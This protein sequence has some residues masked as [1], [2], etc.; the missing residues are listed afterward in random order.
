MVRIRAVM[1]VLLLCVLV[2]GLGALSM[3]AQVWW[4]LPEPQGRLVRGPNELVGVFSGRS[5]GWVVPTDDPKGVVLVDAG[6]QRAASRILA[7]LRK[8]EREVRAILLTHAHSYTTLG[9]EA[10][11]DV[12]VY[13]A[14]EE[15]PL[16]AGE[17]TPIGWL[18]RIYAPSAAPPSDL[19]LVQDGEVVTIDGA[20][21]VAIAT[22][23]HTAGSTTWWW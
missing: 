17:V 8:G 4:S 22:P 23:G 9:L 14:A 2:L 12:P 11:V 13:L 6:G 16:L 15:G 10:F 3:V 19:R 1:S 7:E 21:F 20:K 5:Y 18:A